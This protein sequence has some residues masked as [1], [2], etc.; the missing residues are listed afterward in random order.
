MKTPQVLYKFVSL[1]LLCCSLTFVST[2]SLHAQE[3]LLLWERFD[4]TIVVNGDGT[5]DITEAQ[6]IRFTRGTF[7][8]GARS[9]PMRYLSRI[10]NWSMTDGDGMLYEQAAFAGQEN[11]FTVDQSR[12]QYEVRWFFPPI[13]NESATYVIQYKVHDALRFYEGG[14]Q[15]WWKAIFGD[16][17]FPVLAGQVR[18]VLAD[19]GC[20]CE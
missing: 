3:K 2:A 14:D 19:G 8:Q 7:T 5:L 6:T 11:S 17:P 1:F 10:D 18:V 16:R 20:R 12:G 4:V 13:R 9:I 15:V